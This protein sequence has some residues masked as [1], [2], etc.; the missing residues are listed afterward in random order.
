MRIQERLAYPYSIYFN[1]NA[2]VAEITSDGTNLN[3]STYFGGTNFD[4]GQ[5]IALDGSQIAL[6]HR[7]HWLD[8]LSNR[9]RDQQ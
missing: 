4:E 8:K 6:C 3:Y 7:V 2:F 9:Q 1:A 5:G